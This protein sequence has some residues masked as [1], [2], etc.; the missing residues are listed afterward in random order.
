MEPISQIISTNIKELFQFLK[1]NDFS[2]AVLIGIAI[3]LPIVFGLVFNQLEIGLA[4]GFG[5]FWCSPSHVSGKLTHKINGILLSALLIMIVSFLGGYLHYQTWLIIPV[6]GF[7]TFSIAFIS[8]YGFRASLISFS[9]LLALVLSF[10]HI[11]ET[12]EMYE[13][14]FLIG[15]GG[16]WYLLLVVIWYFINPKAHTEEILAE[17][18][19]LTAVFLE[20]RGKLVGPQPNRDELQAKLLDLQAELV[21]RHATLREILIQS[22][23][24]SGLSHYKGKRL[25]VFVQLV[26]ILEAAIANPVNYD[27]MDVFLKYHPNYVKSFQDFIFEVAKQLRSIS[28]TRYNKR[29]LP[30]NKQ[31][32][33]YL[34]RLEQEVEA[35]KNSNNKSDYEGFLILQN[36]LEY[37]KRQFLKIKRIKWLLGNPNMDTK[38]F[39]DSNE[40]RRFIVSQDYSLNILLRNLSFK[41]NIFKHSLRLAVTVVLGYI[42]GHVFAFQNPYWILLTIIVIMRPSYGLTKVRS[43]DRIIGTLIGGAVA[44]GMVLLIQNPYLYAVLG[45]GSLIIAFSMVQ[46]NYKASATFIT[47]SVVF[48]YGIIEPDISTVIQYRII[49]TVLGAALSYVAMLFL[50]PAWSFLDIHET[51]EMSVQ[52]NKDFLNEIGLYYEQKGQVPTSY[53]VARKTAFLETSNLNSAFQRMAQEPKSKQKHL[54]KIYELVELNHTFLSSLASL[55]T[56][57]QNHPTTEASEMFKEATHK[58]DNYLSLVLKTLQKEVPEELAHLVQKALSENEQLINDMTFLNPKDKHLERQYQEFH[59]VWEQLQWLYAISRNMLKITSSIK[60]N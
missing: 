60:I 13:Y 27:K 6:L 55:S 26:E 41:S 10:A 47:L 25:L 52:A 24:K 56:Y 48:I 2:K 9:G 53:K 4:I 59:L 38:D 39:I 36:Y 33:L 37:Q 30:N 3:T 14:A 8:V 54:D 58:I 16:L 15:L 1:S 23:K 7:L 31:L 57:I 45:I 28:K 34:E 32:I 18:F 20:T 12:L 42:L 5:A 11:S 35:L 46:R 21:E 50:W 40:S 49:D 51:I 17:T 19:L 29:Q 22:R 44:A 43:K